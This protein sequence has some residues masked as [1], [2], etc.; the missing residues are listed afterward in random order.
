V[1]NNV[2][3]DQAVGAP[4][5]GKD[6]VDGLNATDKRYLKQK[7]SMVSTPE[8]ND[9]NNRMSACSMVEEEGKSLAEECARL[10][11]DTS[12]VA[13]VKSDAKYAKRE[14]SAALKMHNYHV[15]KEKMFSLKASK[16]KHKYQT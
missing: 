12:R 6:V 3:I 5:H 10:C 11:S 1:L 9:S 8:E 16:W 7:M 4:G 15:K 14:E 13:G 2:I